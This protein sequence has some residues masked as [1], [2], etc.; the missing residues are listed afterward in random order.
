[1]ILTDIYHVPA[2]ASLAVI[3]GILGTAIAASLI[4]DRRGT[5]RVPG[6][7]PP[8]W[9]NM[10]SKPRTYQMLMAKPS[11]R[12]RRSLVN[13]RNWVRSRLDPDPCGD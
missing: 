8:N 9:R 12:P 10:W 2:F 7:L 13:G 5:T 1:M 6:E 11:P 4:V 3:V